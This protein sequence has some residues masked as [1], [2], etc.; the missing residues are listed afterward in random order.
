MKSGTDRAARAL[1][2]V[3]GGRLDGSAAVAHPGVL[4][5]QDRCLL[6]L[7]ER[8]IVDLTDEQAVRADVGRRAH[9]AIRVSD[10]LVEDRRARGAVVEGESVQRV[11][12]EV[13]LDRL[14]ELA[15][16]GPVLAV[17]DAQREHAALG[18]QLVRHCILLDADAEELRIEAQL[19]DP[20][21]RHR[22]EN[23][24]PQPVVLFGVGTGWGRTHGSAAEWHQARL[25]GEFE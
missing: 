8:G 5:P 17:D 10:R 9:L 2:Y 11:R 19:R 4:H 13:D 23:T 16:D 1:T 22:P 12:L 21:G 14:R 18:D 7:L 15:D 20:V 6:V 24:P 25:S 3:Y